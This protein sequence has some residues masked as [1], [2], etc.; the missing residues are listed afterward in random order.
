MSRTPWPCPT[1]WPTEA[2]DLDAAV[3]AA[4]RTEALALRRYK[5]GAVDYLEVVVAQTAALQARREAEDIETRRLT[6]SI[7][8]VRATGGGWDTSALQAAGAPKQTAG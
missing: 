5:L 3:D 7:A 1:T 4:N 8:L 6:A 2:Q